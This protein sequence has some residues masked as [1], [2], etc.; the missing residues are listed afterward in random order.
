MTAD[1]V[2]DALI[3][4][5][6]R[7]SF[8]I[9]PGVDGRLGVLAKRLFPGVVQRIMDR[10]IRQVSRG[11][12]RTHVIA[13]GR[14]ARDLRPGKR[15]AHLAQAADR[16][17]HI[18]LEPSAIRH[19]AAFWDAARTSTSRIHIAIYNLTHHRTVTWPRESLV[20]VT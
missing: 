3:R 18:G 12:E 2:A 4:G 14:I 6:A 9:I 8:L 17:W 7:R 15:A 1:A 10:T 11:V 5:M 19:M 13:A 16:I 20:I